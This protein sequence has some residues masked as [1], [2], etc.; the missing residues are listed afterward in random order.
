MLR[1]ELLRHAARDP[2]LRAAVAAHCDEL[3]SANTRLISD[4]REH[5]GLAPLPQPRLLA[6][7]FL[8]TALGASLLR[9]AGVELAP[10]GM[11]TLVMLSLMV[12]EDP[13]TSVLAVTGRKKPNSAGSSRARRR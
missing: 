12:G 4:A 6:D 5:L 3:L 13:V 1:L 9:Y 10:V 11:I 2:R 8:A 7:T